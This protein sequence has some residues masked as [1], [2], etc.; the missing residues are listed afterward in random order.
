LQAGEAEPLTEFSPDQKP[1]PM[2]L[3]STQQVIDA[4]ETLLATPR[5]ATV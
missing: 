1:A 3:I 2:N 5:V 4:M